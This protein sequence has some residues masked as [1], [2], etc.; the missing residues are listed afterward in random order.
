MRPTGRIPTILDQMG[1]PRAPAPAFGLQHGRGKS[2]GE[3]PMEAGSKNLGGLSPEVRAFYV[4]TLTSL[5]ESGIPFLVGGAYALQRY[6]GVERHT[7]D[8]D[9]FLRRDD[10]DRL[11]RAMD[12]LGCRTEVT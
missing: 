6:T 5:N 7:K 9:L 2:P 1:K 4:R 12:G 11:L 8:F 10:L 3:A